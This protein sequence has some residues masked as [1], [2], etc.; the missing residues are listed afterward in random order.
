MGL[1]SRLS[2]LIPD[3]SCVLCAE[4]AKFCVCDECESSFSNHQSRCKSCAHPIVG[5]LDFCGQCLAHAPAFNRAYT[6]Y[7]YQGAIAD[8]IKIFKFDHRLCVGDY[9]SHQLFDLYQSIV[10]KDTQYDAIIPMPLSNSRM[11]ERGYNQV[12]ELLSVISKKTN[13][14]IDSH[15][16]DRIKATQPLSALN[17][18]QRKQEIKGAFSV[19]PISYDRVLLVDDV[20]TTGSSLNE[21]AITILKNTSVKHCDVMTLARAESKF[22]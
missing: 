1:Y 8:L 19:N 13:T 22:N 18:E 9:F 5:K 15:S 6:L 3:Q 16:V 11:T 4:N 20:M 10:S 17:P 2:A 7:D 14:I 21:L 12:L